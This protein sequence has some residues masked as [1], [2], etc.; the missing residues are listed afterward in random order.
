[1]PDRAAKSSPPTVL[2]I[3][4]GNYYRSRFAEAWF[5]HLALGVGS[6]WRAFSRGVAIDL[7]PPGLSAYTRAYLEARGVP[8]HLTAPERQPL[9]ESDL[10]RATCAIA[11]KEAEHR[12][13]L[14]RDFPHWENRVLYWHF[15]DVDVATAA[16]MLPR[17]ERHVTELFRSLPPLPAPER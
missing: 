12:P 17:L 7:A 15:H 9:T 10:A 13:Y 4:T 2:F 11:L 5:N 3:C 6:P 16:E 14:R 8:L 1:M